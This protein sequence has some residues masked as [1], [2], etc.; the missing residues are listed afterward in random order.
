MWHRAFKSQQYQV[1]AD[2]TAPTHAYWGTR[3]AKN[4]LPDN[5]GSTWIASSTCDQVHESI[6]GAWTVYARGG[7]NKT[8]LASAYE[9]F[10]D[11][12][13]PADGNITSDAQRRNWKDGKT[14]AALPFLAKMAAAL[15]EPEDASGWTALY[16][17]YGPQFE[18]S[19]GICGDRYTC[20][21]G[22]NSYSSAF[23]LPPY[24]SD[25]RAALQAK[26][27]L[28]NSVTGH[29]PP[30]AS[31][32]AILLATPMNETTPATGPWIAHTT[33]TYEAIDG[34]FRHDVHDYAVE[35]TTG[36]IRDMQRTYGWTIFPEAWSVRGGPWGDQWYNWGSCASVSLVLERLCGV[37]Y[38]AVDRAPNATSDGILT[39][40]DALPD[41]WAEATVGVPMAA[42]TMVT[43]TLERV[44]ATAKMISVK[45]N[46]LGALRIQP[47]VG[48]QHTVLSASPLGW[49]K[50]LPAGNRLG[51]TFVGEAAQNATVIVV[52]E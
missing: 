44:N 1:Y 39:V 52:W 11:M 17:R 23:V 3:F 22:I 35:L 2:P 51:W 6:E 28:M 9:L 14:L 37:D 34:L 49:A 4:E 41:D 38:T 30:N 21:D 13:I 15:G 26:Q 12:A 16:E 27:F 18:K 7:G 32:G 33:Y 24:G 42:G 29:F 20:N 40:R 46:P 10:K 47:W 36:H 19:W 8:Y 50:E 5:M 31:F 25:E 43:V 45:G 48:A